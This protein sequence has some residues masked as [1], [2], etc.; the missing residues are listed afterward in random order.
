MSRLKIN[1]SSYFTTFPIKLK[2]VHIQIRKFKT[3]TS[4]V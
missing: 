2:I 3:K 4:K 1:V